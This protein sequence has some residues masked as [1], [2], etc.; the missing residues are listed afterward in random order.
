MVLTMAMS[1]GASTC[2]SSRSVS[3]PPM[4]ETPTASASVSPPVESANAVTPPVSDEGAIFLAIRGAGIVRL[5][6][7]GVTMVYPTTQTLVDM[8]VGPRGTVW[9]SYYE[10][11]TIRVRDGKAE[12]LSKDRYK[13]FGVRAED[14]VWALT[15]DIE[16]ELAHYDGTKWSKIKKRADFK[17][18]YDDNKPNDLAVTKDAVWVSSWNGL[19]RSSGQEW[20]RVGLPAAIQTGQAPSRLVTTG[21]NLVAGFAEGYF[22]W[23]G[24]GWRASP[25]PAD[26]WLRDMNK[27]GFAAGSTADSRRIVLGSPSA[28]NKV[29]SSDSIPAS[30]IHDLTV[31]ERGRV[32]IAGDYALIVLDPA[33]RVLAA[34]E[35]GT[36]RGVTGSVDRIVAAGVGPARLPG[37]EAI[38]T[39]DIL[40]QVNLSKSGRPLTSAR[41]ELCSS[42]VKSGC[43]G[44]PFSR[45]ATTG[46]DG[47][48]R[49][50]GVPPGDFAIHVQ[51]PAGIPE[52]EGIF[53]VVPNAAVSVERDCHVAA[54]APRVCTIRPLRVC[55]PFEMPP[56]R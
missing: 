27:A 10:E 39:W 34:W 24:G 13:H 54:G 30:R 40:G 33:G 3:D 21:T 48:F 45:S 12:V 56:R 11:G 2:G 7:G 42:P 41:V 28:A 14:D 35:P 38:S 15:D 4:R 37:K 31:D 51:V 23:S 26:A 29:K 52:C 44:A 20:E 22:T 50:T 25:W 19:F 43:A 32:W 36:L 9:A 1:L 47:S 53:R 6:G 18:R 16:W 17:G 46:A 8:A 49:L 5:D 55:L